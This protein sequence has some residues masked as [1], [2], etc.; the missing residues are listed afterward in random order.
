MLECCQKPREHHNAV[1][2]KYEQKQYKKA[3]VYVETE[4][5]K[6]F[7]LPVAVKRESSLGMSSFGI[8]ASTASTPALSWRSQTQ[9]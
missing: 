3:S 5:A 6:G 2:E 1:F 9:K 7:E 4:V 8:A